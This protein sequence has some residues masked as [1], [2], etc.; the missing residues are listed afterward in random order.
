MLEWIAVNLP[1]LVCFVVGIGL[2]VLEAFMP[3]FGLPGI[4]GIVMEIVAIVLTWV[5]HGPVA[6]LGLTIIVLSL[7][8][9]AISMSL[10]SATRGR[11]SRSKIILKER[12]SNEAGYRSAE[13]MQ[14]FL[15]REG[16]TT[17][18]C[19]PTGMAEFDGVKLNVVSEGE[20]IPAGTRVRIVLVE[21]SRIVVRVIKG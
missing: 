7:I 13:D 17:T 18:V 15:G 2:L 12:E 16:E 10:R 8:A 5:N 3:G 20:F 6:A 14:V 21:G 19:R 1:L 4:S 9:I 11:L